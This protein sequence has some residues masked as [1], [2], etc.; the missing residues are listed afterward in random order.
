MAMS[1]EESQKAK[2]G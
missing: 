2:W 1:R